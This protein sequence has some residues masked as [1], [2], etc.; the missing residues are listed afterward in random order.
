MDDKTFEI[1]KD[2][3]TND[4]CWEFYHSD[5]EHKGHGVVA[6]TREQCI[7]YLIKMNKNKLKE[8][9][10]ELKIKNENFKKVKTI[11]EKE[12]NK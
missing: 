10:N 3:E 9:K 4:H 7:K 6:K 1:Y 5:K 2:E 11:L 12:N 8:L